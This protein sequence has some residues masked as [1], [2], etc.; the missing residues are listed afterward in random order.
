ME[1]RPEGTVDDAVDPWAWVNQAEDADAIDLD[2]HRVTAVLV[3]HDGAEWVPAALNGLTGLTHAPDQVVLVDAGSSDETGE[4]F[5][6]AAESHEWRSAPARAGGG[7]DAVRQ[8]LDSL[9][10]GDDG[11]TDWVW[12]LHDDA[13]ARPDALA[14]LLT[15]AVERQARMATPRLVQPATRQDPARVSELG[16]S[17]A[18]SG[19]RE[20]HVDAGEIDQGQHDTI[21]EVLGD[22]KSTRLNCSHV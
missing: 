12:L 14:Q 1:T 9:Q 5:A 16:V 10:G 7:A 8:G 4:L 18:R 11:R 17:V 2:A 15:A 6:A 3:A 19:R 21:N 22:R 13:V 20:V